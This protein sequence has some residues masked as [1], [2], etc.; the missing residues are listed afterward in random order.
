MEMLEEIVELIP[1]PHSRQFSKPE[2]LDRVPGVNYIITSWKS[3]VIDEDILQAADALEAIFHSTGTVQPYVCDQVFE[4][5][6]LVTTSNR[7]M[8]QVTA[9]AGV[10]M[11]MMGNWGA[12]YWIQAMQRGEW[13]TSETLVPGM[14]GLKFG[15]VGFGAVTRNMLPMLRP[16]R[17]LQISIY[18]NHLSDAEA[19]EH[20]LRKMELD[21]MIADSDI[22]FLQT[23][24]TEKTRHLIDARRLKLIKDDALLVNLGRGPLIDEDAL[25]EALSENRFRAVL[26]VFTEEPLPADSTLRQLPNVICLPHIGAATRFCREEMGRDVVARMKDVIA[27]KAPAG[28]VDMDTAR[29]MSLK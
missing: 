24:L 25:V 12:R 27:G 14:Q 4:K 26:D 10:V 1:N 18:S 23:S 19:G 8:S 29:R 3:P 20:G 22:L 5:G 16:F 17:P 11:A 2:L 7:I 9:E 13:K 28:I 15:I 6:I 21:A